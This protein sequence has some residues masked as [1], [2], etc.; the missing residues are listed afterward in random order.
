[1]ALI[2]QPALVNR[3]NRLRPPRSGRAQPGEKIEI[4]GQMDEPDRLL[5]EGGG[6]PK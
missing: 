3:R 5:V 1:M 4:G 2:P 6:V